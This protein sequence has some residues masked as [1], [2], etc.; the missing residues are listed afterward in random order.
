MSLYEITLLRHA[1]SEGNL[2]RKPQGHSDLPLTE[3]GRRQAQALANRWEAEGRNFDRILCSPLLRAKSTAEI[4]LPVLGAPIEYE[5]LWMERDMGQMVDLDREAVDEHYANP[6]SR[7]PFHEA[8]GQGGEGQWALYLRAGQALHELM[9]Q[10]A[11]AYLVISHG[12]LLNALMYAIL[13]LGPQAF[14]NGP[15]FFF[16]NA[17]FAN[18]RYESDLHRWALLHFNDTA[19]LE[20]LE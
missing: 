20:G 10:E 13:G 9:N 3:L 7:S 1:Q 6:Q 11:G 2:A 16:D 18:L 12:G 5:A 8:F 14:G 4:L 19:H 17:G 15:R